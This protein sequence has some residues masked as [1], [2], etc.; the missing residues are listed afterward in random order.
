[1]KYFFSYHAGCYQ[2]EGD[3][4]GEMPAASGVVESM[5]FLV[6]GKVSMSGAWGVNEPRIVFRSGVLVVEKEHEGGSGGMPPVNSAGKDGEV[7]FNSGSGATGSTFSSPEV[8]GE[9]FFCEGY[10]GRTS[11]KDDSQRGPM[12]FS[13]KAYTKNSSETVHDSIFE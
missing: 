11:V 2:G 3:A 9:V 7:V 10:A 4:P 1:M 6:A 13:K 8:R 12:G 5:K